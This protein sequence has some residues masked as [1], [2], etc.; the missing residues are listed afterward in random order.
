MG[1]DDWPRPRRCRGAGRSLA[2]ISSVTLARLAAQGREPG[3]ASLPQHVVQAGVQGLEE[4]LRRDSL[5]DLLPDRLYSRRCSCSRVST[6]VE[7]P[8][9]PVAGLHAMRSVGCVDLRALVQQSARSW[10]S[11]TRWRSCRRSAVRNVLAPLAAAISFSR[12]GLVL[13]GVV[14]PQLHIGVRVWSGYCGRKHSGV[15]SRLSRGAR[16]RR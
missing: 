2:A 7:L 12:F 14:L 1:V 5:S 11:P 4:V 9:D 8:D 15:P 3:Q 13:R 10:G 16:C 6:P